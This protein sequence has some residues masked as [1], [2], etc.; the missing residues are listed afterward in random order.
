[1][2]IAG[3]LGLIIRVY[4]ANVQQTKGC[5]GRKQLMFLSNDRLETGN[6]N[7]DL[8]SMLQQLIELFPIRL[9]QF[10]T[11]CTDQPLPLAMRLRRLSLMISGVRRSS[12]VI[13]RI[14]AS[15]NLS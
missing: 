2:R 3:H 4:R 11:S 9:C 5:I 1:M 12:F 6:R 14:M 7:T 10:L 13:E 8:L 15:T